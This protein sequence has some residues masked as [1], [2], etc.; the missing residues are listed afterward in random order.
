MS[1]GRIVLLVFGIIFLLISFGLL[2][3]GGVILAFEGA[4]RDQDGFYTIRNIPV[5]ISSNAL[6]TEPADIHTGPAWFWDQSH[7]VT[8]RVVATSNIEQKPI[9]IG[10]ARTNDLNQYLGNANYDQVTN[11]SIRPNRIG[12]RHHSG[13]VAP[14]PPTSQNFWVASATGSG[15]QT[16]QWDV[17]PGNYT[18]ALMNADATSPIS[19]QASLGVKIP[20]VLRTIGWGLLIGGIVLLIIGGIMVYFAARGW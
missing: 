8:I 18:L 5:Q 11:F 13:T 4:L 20:L 16:L 10:I 7:P 3:G 6:V 9:F 17:A 2:I 15:A 1:A 14:A 12:T 19:A